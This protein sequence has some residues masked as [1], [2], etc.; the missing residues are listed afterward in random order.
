VAEHGGDLKASRTLDVHEE[1]IRALDEPL[2]LMGSGL[3]FGGGVQ[4]ID[5]HLWIWM[6]YE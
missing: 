2:E 4:K 1:A 5:R 6:C 3:L